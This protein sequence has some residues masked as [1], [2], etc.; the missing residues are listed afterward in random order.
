MN[1]AGLV[2]ILVRIRD[3]ASAALGNMAGSA[4]QAS[5]RMEE[6]AADA[7][8]A[9]E[10]LERMRAVS[11]RASDG[12]GRLGG[13][14]MKVAGALGAVNPAAGAVA[15]GVGDMA[16]V[17]EVASEVS[18]ALGVSLGS[19]LAIGA[20]LLLL[21]AGLA[22]EHKAA[23]A[24]AERHA[25]AEQAVAT[26]QQNAFGSVVAL[27]SAVASLADRRA[28]LA[29]QMS[30]DQLQASEEARGLYAV[31]RAAHAAAAEQLRLA[32]AQM[33]LKKGY[34]ETSPEYREAA[35]ALDA[36]RT[37]MARVL[38]LGRQLQEDLPAVQAG[39]RESV[40]LAEA[41]ADAERDKAEALREAGEEEAKA[42]E[43]ARRA[44]VLFW[45][46]VDAA[47]TST[48]LPTPDKS[49]AVLERWSE[50]LDALDFS[51]KAE[52]AA[53]LAIAIADLNLA[54][55]RGLIDGGQYDAAMAELA[56]RQAA[57]S[58]AV[59]TAGMDDGV[60]SAAG[61]VSA[62]SSGGSSFLSSFG[63]WGQIIAAIRDLVVELDNVLAGFSDWHQETMDALAKLPETLVGSLE[64]I[65]SDSY[66]TI[67]D[68]LLR[69][70]A[71]N[72]DELLV[73][74][75]RGAIDVL[76]SVL[77]AVIADLPGA[78]VELLGALFD[79]DLWW[80]V[81]LAIGEGL[82]DVL[83]EALRDLFLGPK[84][85]GVLVQAGQGIGSAWEDFKGWVGSFD[86]G[87]R[88][89]AHDGVAK[90]HQGERILRED[91]LPT[92]TGP[93]VELHV[94]AVAVTEAGARELAEQVGRFL[95]PAGR[96]L[97]LS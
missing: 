71:D 21:V 29:G 73:G 22:V 68:D 95:G 52:D 17:V 80:D 75:V 10:R 24:A 8:R 70:L 47:A 60:S 40:R 51:G 90:V 93:R 74:I 42:I 23:A 63:P 45:E 61:A 79:P 6:L 3:E 15:Q 92:E 81:G 85:E 9:E 26:A 55:S 97:A 84:R 37:Q 2:E 43:R 35:V 77:E 5:G 16:D 32:E 30:E 48:Y 53:E 66:V 39:E 7:A 94:H 41:R 13:N 96:N 69:S 27:E 57:A 4:G 87:T 25:A 19:V 1:A 36:A 28:V 65:F 91:Q 82:V 46:G 56:R 50:A 44:K 11:E 78:L 38:E 89:V 59:S 54:F 83:M 33:V 49:V 76:G 62:F 64:D 18:M 20:P 72:L 34:A 67:L 88:Y 12:A 14:A 58:T 86:V 31:Q